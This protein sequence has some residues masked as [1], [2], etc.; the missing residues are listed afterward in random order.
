[1]DVLVDFITE[2]MGSISDNSQSPK[3]SE[4]PAHDHL[5]VIALLIRFEDNLPEMELRLNELIKLH[6]AQFATLLS[7]IRNGDSKKALDIIGFTCAASNT[8]VL[9]RHSERLSIW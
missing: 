4:G 7:S 3:S 6:Q 9:P 1:M 5:D 2:L 8:F